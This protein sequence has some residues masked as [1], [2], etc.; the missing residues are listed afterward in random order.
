MDLEAQLPKYSV[1][2]LMTEQQL[3]PGSINSRIQIQS[4]PDRPMNIG[5]LC[6]FMNALQRT[7]TVPYRIKFFPT[8]I[9]CSLSAQLQ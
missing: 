6:E 4:L 2:Y 7:R 8:S 9:F 1:P 3:I 5:R